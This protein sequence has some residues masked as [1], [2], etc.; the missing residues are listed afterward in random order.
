MN[1]V[2]AILNRF[3]GICLITAILIGCL[4]GYGAIG[5]RYLIRASQTLFY[6]AE[7]ATST[8]LHRLLAPADEGLACFLSLDGV[9][10]A[11]RRGQF[12]D[13]R[14]GFGHGLQFVLWDD[15]SSLAN[16]RSLG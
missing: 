7:F 13:A 4:G 10:D 15:E 6:G 1:Y 2:Q 12:L 14:I 5:F 8:S 11:Q 16:L 3:L 9:L